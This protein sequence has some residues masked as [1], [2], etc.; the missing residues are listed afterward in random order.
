MNQEGGAAVDVAAQ[1]AKPLVSGV[2]R[3]DHNVIQLV[4]Q[5]VLDHALE[6][7]LDFKKIRQNADGRE[8]ALHNSGLKKPANRFRGISMFGDHRF[9]RAFFSL[10]CR[11]FSAKQIE[12]GLRFCFFEALGVDQA[13]ELVN[14]FINARDT[15]G[16]GFELE[17]ELATL[18]AKS[19]NLG[20]CVA[21][22]SL[23]AARFAI[24]AGETF[25][26]LGELVAKAGSRRNRIE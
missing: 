23:H 11:E 19:L 6:T 21:D 16:H 1:Q 7:W 22:F 25:L 18:S 3:F 9:E 20:V 17:G 26:C 15:L 12:M 4:A 13:A 24:R 5:K 8:A 14:L 10:G 2:P